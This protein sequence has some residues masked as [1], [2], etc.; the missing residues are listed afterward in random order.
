MGSCLAAELSNYIQY[1][2]FRFECSAQ[3]LSALL[4]KAHSLQNLKASPLQ[5]LESCFF[6]PFEKWTVEGGQAGTDFT[7]LRNLHNQLRMLEDSAQHELMETIHYLLQGNTAVVDADSAFKLLDSQHISAKLHSPSSVLNEA[8]M[9]AAHIRIANLV[10]S[11]TMP[12]P[13]KSR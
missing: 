8:Q 13:C 9:N 12:V 7:N 5:I 1:E 11:N 4:D 10:T 3:D 2:P 6:D